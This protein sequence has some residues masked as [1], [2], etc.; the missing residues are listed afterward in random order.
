MRLFVGR[1]VV[2]GFATRRTIKEP[3]LAEPN[4]QL[5]LAK[6]AKLFAVAFFLTHFAL[7]ADILLSGTGG[8]AHNETL[9]RLPATLQIPE[10]TVRPAT[11]R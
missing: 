2:A 7:H 8:G 5:A 1:F 6:T 9:S 4:I 11:S 3:V 10:V